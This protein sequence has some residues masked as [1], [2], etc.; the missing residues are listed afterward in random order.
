VGSTQARLH[1]LWALPSWALMRLSTP[2]FAEG[3]PWEG[4]KFGL[5]EWA[6]HRTSLTAHFDTAMWFCAFSVTL[7]LTRIIFSL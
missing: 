3:H 1:L 7:I 6:T 5:Y 2:Y 4:A